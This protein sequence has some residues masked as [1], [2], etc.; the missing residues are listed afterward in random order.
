L[1]EGDIEISRAAQQ[2]LKQEQVGGL[3]VDDEQFGLQDIG[4]V[5]HALFN[6][7]KEMEGA[8]KQMRQIL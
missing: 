7:K 1:C 4:G 6:R 3:I 8:P 2:S 5:D